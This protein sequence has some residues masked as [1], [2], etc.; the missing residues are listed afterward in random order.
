MPEV[1]LSY[2]DRPLRPAKSA[3]LLE[4]S[5]LFSPDADEALRRHVFVSHENVFHRLPH[6]HYV[7]KTYSFHF[8]VPTVTTHGITTSRG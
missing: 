4:P 2:P 6:T 7:L 3:D 8:A 1:L 5:S